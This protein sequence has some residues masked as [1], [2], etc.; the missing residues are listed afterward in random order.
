[1]KQRRS[2][3][4]SMPL[5]AAVCAAVSAAHASPLPG[6]DY[7]SVQ[8]A[9][10]PDAKLLDKLF[11][12]Y[13]TLPFLRI[14]RRG[15]LHVLRAG[16]WANAREARI[17][18][19]IAPSASDSAAMLLRVATFRPETVV[20]RNWEDAAPAI[21]ESIAASVPTV[22]DLV[23]APSPVPAPAP[24]Q[25]IP[26]GQHSAPGGTSPPPVAEDEQLR[27]FDPE[28]YAL[29]F[30]AFLGSGDR[31]R[32]FRLARKAV[33]SV[34]DDH[35]WRRKL[36][37]LAEW[38]HRPV[39]AWEQWDILFRRGD[40]SEETLS[41]VLRLA[42]LAP[43]SD[44]ALAVWRMRAERGKLTDAQWE[45]IYNL[46]ELAAKAQQ[47][48]Q[49]FERQ[50]RRNGNI[51]L[52]EYAAQLADNIGEDERALQLYTERANLKPFSIDSILR[53]TVFLLR[54]DQL[55]EAYTLMEAHREEAP[56][57][58]TEYWNILGNIAWELAETRTAEFAL[59][60]QGEGKQ[61]STTDWSRLIFLLRQQ[62]PQ[63]AAD[64]AFETYRRYGNSDNLLYALTLH[65]ERGDVKAQAKI[66]KSIDLEALAKLEKDSRFLVSRAQYYQ[67]IQDREHAW[68]DYQRALA[69]KPDDVE[70][71]VPTLWFLIDAHRKE[72]LLTML[73]QQSQSARAESAS[74]YWLPFAAAYHSLDRYKDALY[75]Y[76]K[77]IERSPDDMLLLLNY[78]DALERVQLGGMAERVRR[79]A[80][81]RLREKFPKPE[82]VTPLDKNPE[83]LALARLAILNDPGDPGLALVRKVVEQL[84]GVGLGADP[85]VGAGVDAPVENAQQTKDLILGWAV[86]KEQFLNARTWMWLNYARRAKDRAP[87]W[88][89]SQT[90]LQL[91]DT[92]TMD[93]LLNR[94]G[95]GLPI[96]NRY[97]T[98]HALDHWPLALDIA[99]RGLENNDVDEALYDRYRSH[100]PQ[101]A[102]YIQVRTS[103][104]T[105]GS[106]DSREQ[107]IEL[108][109]VADRRLH[110]RFGVSQLSQS[111][112]D[113]ALAAPDRQ[114]LASVEAR[115]L[116]HRGDTTFSL[117]HRNELAGQSGWQ[118]G[119]IWAWSARLN[120]NGS[121]AHHAEATDSLPL[122]VG[123]AED[124]LRMGL[125]YAI[126]K[127]EYFAISPR[128]T[129]Y[130]T[131]YGDYLGSGRI[132]DVEAGYRIRTEYPDWRLRAFA[133]HQS[134]TRD[135]AVG[136]QALA[137]LA[138]DVRSAIANGSLDAL[139]YFIPDGSTTWGVCFGM[140]ENLAG[141]NLQ[142]VY[143]RA[144]RHFYDVCPNH[145][146][147]NGG[148][149]TGTLGLAGSLSGE[150]HLSLRMEQS[151]GGSSSG[152]LA[153]SLSARYKHY[154]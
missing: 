105:Y 97:D 126:G 133:T 28:D 71:V 77:E 118:L 150:D 129:R 130:Y 122:R 22:A 148:G 26:A 48:S 16:F 50:Y 87:L 93:R 31:E 119:Q 12:K 6:K 43:N 144:W 81:L 47:G 36:A 13:A 116:G 89:D 9:S 79:H 152:S 74:A 142:D 137:S 67:M 42:P 62:H 86:S 131:Q 90:A 61:A 7:Y 151:S 35:D 38:T 21:P 56:T 135:G 82:L 140:G 112:N 145:N 37:R 73:Q 80:W 114:R 102:N 117:F 147:L 84:R 136:A 154:F 4:L 104:D 40:H 27:P 63:Q 45:D 52:L 146:T 33:A 3:Y 20:R 92:E 139:K 68:S 113:P 25:A 29:A 14:E 143:S 88:G 15:S 59:R 127:R 44:A 153:R 96:Y 11:V 2:A 121:I 78:A 69:L 149:Y 23:K 115:W 124:H 64:L 75:W 111:T 91:G 70:V 41:A 53:A 128:L 17:E 18:A 5:V 19:R 94:Q 110:L 60:R 66:F 138:P 1:M 32:A 30:D 99:F 141:Q 49:F 103:S 134:F 10:S 101:H 106:L 123:G 54:R 100:A 34:P 120:L 72:A 8:I 51:R 39:L 108:K 46:Y 107:Q 125:N 58:A 85:G 109:L 57:E 55:R 132:L 24:V 65:G 98:A 83:L 95:D 76:R